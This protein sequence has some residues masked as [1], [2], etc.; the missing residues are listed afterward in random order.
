MG[1]PDGAGLLL[2]TTRD[3]APT[4]WGPQ[5]RLVPLEP[6]DPGPS[7]AA[8]RD[9]APAAGTAEEAAALGERLGGLPLAVDTAGHYLANPT[10][11]YRTFTAYRHAL[12]T[13]SVTSSVPNTRRQPQPPPGT[14]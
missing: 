11:R 1:A 12:A 13:S 3:T 7:G 2:V 6:L 5:A 14:V 8:L 4:T 10:S 9:A